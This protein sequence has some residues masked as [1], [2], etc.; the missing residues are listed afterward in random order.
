MRKK[1]LV[2]LLLVMLGLAFVITI[3]GCGKIKTIRGEDLPMGPNINAGYG[4]NQL[5]SG[6]W[7][8]RPNNPLWTRLFSIFM[9]DTSGLSVD[10]INLHAVNLKGQTVVYH[11]NMTP[12]QRLG[13][14]GFLSG[15]Q[16]T[17][18]YIEK[19]EVLDNGNYV[20][21]LESS[22]KPI[23]DKSDYEEGEGKI[24]CIHLVFEVPSQPGYYILSGADNNFLF[25]RRQ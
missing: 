15:L 12:T 2:I 13:V 4:W 16:P 11:Y 20:L 24:C 6:S 23:E 9:T 1:P 10:E 21:T 17:S 22:I 19:L 18:V 25:L 7:L 3:A 8:P 14:S 5:G